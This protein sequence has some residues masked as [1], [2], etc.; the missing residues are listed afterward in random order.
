MTKRKEVDEAA[1]KRIADVF[2]RMPAG[3]SVAPPPVL[4]A[5]ENTPPEASRVEGEARRVVEALG[6]G[7]WR[8]W[9]IRRL[10]GI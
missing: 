4:A 5:D 3:E 9:L 8:A 7:G 1:K 10:A 2:A 6:R